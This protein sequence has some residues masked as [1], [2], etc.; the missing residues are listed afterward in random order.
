MEVT[1]KIIE[2]IKTDFDGFLVIIF[3][4][5]FALTISIYASNKRVRRSNMIRKCT[6]CNFIGKAYFKS[7]D[8]GFLD[9]IVTI[10]FFILCFAVWLICSNKSMFIYIILLL[11]IS[12]LFLLYFKWSLSELIECPDCGKIN[13]MIPAE[14]P[15]GQ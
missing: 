8:T 3:S 7:K 6:A 1:A 11:N 12:I 10:C 9:I 2:L 4:L 15:E 5:L 13:S 14:S